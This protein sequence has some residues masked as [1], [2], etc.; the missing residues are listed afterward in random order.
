MVKRAFKVFLDSNVILSGFLSERGAPRII[1]DLLSLRLPFLIGSTGRYNLIEIER[2]LKKK[3]PNLFFL[4]KTYL[5]KLNLKVIPLPRPK[6]VRDFSGQIAEKD[7]PVL[8]SAI[9]SKADFLVTGDKQHFE[10]MKGLDKYPFDVVA[11]SEFIDSILPEILK[12]L[13]EKE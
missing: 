3:M 7:V 9:R 6:E 10:K 2:N 5:P 12:E 8:I 4:Y 13:E 11:P 1:L